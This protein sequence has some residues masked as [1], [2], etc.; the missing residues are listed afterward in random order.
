M[1]GFDQDQ[2]T[3]GRTEIA[4]LDLLVTA[5]FESCLSLVI[6]PRRCGPTPFYNPSSVE[7]SRQ[8][9]IRSWC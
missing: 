3:P 5:T 1:G 2:W 9:L 6:G 8:G 4:T 7:G